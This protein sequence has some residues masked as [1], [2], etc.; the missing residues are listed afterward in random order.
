MAGTHKI[1]QVDVAVGVEK[2]VV[3]L[4]IS[5]MMFWLWIYFRAHPSSAI[6]NLTASSVKVFLEMWNRKS[7]PVIKSTTMYLSLRVSHKH[8]TPRQGIGGVV[9]VLDILEA[10]SQVANEGVVEVFEHLPLAD[11][12]SYALGSY[13]CSHGMI[14]SAGVNILRNLR[15]QGFEAEGRDVVETGNVGW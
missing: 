9:H 10:V 3:G 1:G 6:Q 11:D 8:G 5:G 14:V 7:P 4:D 2:D 12:V 13:D 15:R